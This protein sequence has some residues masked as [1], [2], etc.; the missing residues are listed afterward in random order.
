MAELVHR[1]HES[2]IEEIAAAWGEAGIGRDQIDELLVYCAERKC[3]DAAATCPGCR[4]RTQVEGFANVEDFVAAHKE[5]AIG[6]GG[7]KIE[8]NGARSASFDSFEA[9]SRG[10]AGEEYWFWARRVLRKLRHGVRR[11]H[12]K[13]E[14][15]A[16]EGETPS[17]ILIEPQL[18]D[19]IGM[20]ARA[21]ANFGLDDLRLV[22]PRDGWPNERARIAASGANYVIDEGQSHPSLAEAMGDLNWVCATTARQR[23]LRKPVLSPEQAVREM[24]RRIGE[25]QRCGMMFGREASGLTTAEVAEAD[26]LVMIPV[27]NKFASINLAQAVLILGYCWI[28]LRESTV[29]GRATTYE[30]PIRPGFNIGKD[31]PATKEE[32]TN[33]FEHLEAEL[34]AAEFFRPVQRKGATVLS[35]RTMFHRMEATRHEVSALRGVVKALARARGRRSSQS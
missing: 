20:V 27:N 8:G 25:G 17:V 24:K 3:I 29:V 13:G 31:Q 19:N 30:R 6:H 11:T 15:V 21:M 22:S 35:L 4:R 1:S 9:F 16:G 12:I 26:A 5:I 28:Q 14:P 33:F 34:E 18:A 10:W 23:D 32:L 2:G 7:A